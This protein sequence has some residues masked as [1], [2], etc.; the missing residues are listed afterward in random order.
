MPGVES[1]F[2]ECLPSVWIREWPY[3][4]TRT[5]EKAV[6][7]QESGQTWRLGCATNISCYPRQV[8]E[9]TKSAEWEKRN[10]CS[11]LPYIFIMRINETVLLKDFIFFEDKDLCF[12]GGVL[13]V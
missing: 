5:Y 2:S 11:W 1:A 8:L 3:D 10:D 12:F 4:D 7:S 9:P 6:I 13:I